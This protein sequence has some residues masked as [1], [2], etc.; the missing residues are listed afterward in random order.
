VRLGGVN[1]YGSRVEHRP[2]LGDGRP[3]EPDDIRRAVRLS[4][5]VG[6]A[7]AGLAAGARLAF[8]RGR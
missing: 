4:R 7:A 5:A 1:V 6:F 8:G 2:E 3:P